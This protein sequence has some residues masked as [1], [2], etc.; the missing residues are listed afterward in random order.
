MHGT[1]AVIGDPVDHSLSPL[2][3][4]AAFRKL[5]MDCAYISFRIQGNELRDGLESL[6]AAKI[7]GFNVTI[8]HKVAIMDMLDDVDPECTAVGACNTVTV[9]A[10]K[11]KGYNTDVRGF[12]EPLKR[13]SVTLDSANTLVLGT[14]GAARA[15]VHGLASKNAK[16]TVA[17]RSV[18]K[19]DDI[20][21]CTNATLNTITFDDVAK[22]AAKSDIIINATPIGMNNE[23]A[24]VPADSIQSNATVYDIVYS[25]LKTRLISN[26]LERGALVIYGYE[27]LLAQA[28]L[29]FEI[30]HKTFAPYDAM[31]QALFGMHGP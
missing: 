18:Q 31:K 5:G 9:N 16:I 19:L 15:V 26:A 3:H 10:G 1:Y 8:P 12:L 30:W 11:L 6:A 13:H 29:S 28:A 21:S 22:V 24:P 17:G 25:P 27:M 20:T 14:G 4:N 23:L 7:A 2:I